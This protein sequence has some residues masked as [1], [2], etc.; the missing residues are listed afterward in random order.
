M[1][2][3]ALVIDDG[4]QVSADWKPLPEIKTVPPA[5]TEDGLSVIVGDGIVTVNDAE[6]EGPGTTLVLVKI[7]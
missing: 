5:L 1:F 3:G 4:P 7:T 2:D 6:I